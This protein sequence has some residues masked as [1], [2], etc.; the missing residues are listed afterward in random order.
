MKR[1]REHTVYVLTHAASGR[2]YVGCTGVG[3]DARLRMH[4]TEART[5]SLRPIYTAIREF[6]LEAFT[7]EIV[8][9]GERLEAFGR[10][11]DEIAARGSLHPAGFNLP[12]GRASKARCSQLHRRASAATTPTF[13]GE[14]W[15]PIEGFYYEVS[16]FGRVRRMGGG[17]RKT[18]VL[19]NGH[20]YVDLWHRNRGKSFL[21]S[22][23]VC[24]AFHGPP[25]SPK[26][27]ADHGD[28]DTQNNRAGNLKWL[29]P[30]EN[31][32]RTGNWGE[33]HRRAKLT[34]AD[35]LKIRSMSGDAAEIAKRFGVTRQNIN[36]IRAR[37]AWTHI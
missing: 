11:R 28:T 8:F 27:Q 35:V 19:K 2:Q 15:R 24:T 4:A 25:P 29:T 36:F 33:G 10:E 6:G 22:R 26:H 3:L 21:V 32:R 14:E 20:V 16:N 9:T 31:V 23:L 18:R 13:D 37:K 1:R 7:A 34:E 30:T 5:G 12:T 17:V